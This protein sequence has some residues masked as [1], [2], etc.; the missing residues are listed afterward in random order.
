MNKKKLYKVSY[1]DKNSVAQVETYSAS[2]IIMLFM[3]LAKEAVYR[4]SEYGLRK[5]IIEEILNDDIN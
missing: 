2:D 3:V 5:L 1:I 4:E